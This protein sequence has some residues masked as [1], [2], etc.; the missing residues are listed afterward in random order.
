M[1][2]KSPRKRKK[3]PSYYADNTPPSFDAGVCDEPLLLF[4]GHHAHIDPKT[5]L[6]L[7]GPYSLADQEKPPLKTIKVGIVGPPGMVSDARNWLTTIQN[8]LLNDGKEPYLYP[9]F[10]GI[11]SE[12]AFQCD[13]V[14]G[15]TWQEAISPERLS[16]VLDTPDYYERLR[17]VV[18]L[19]VGR[20][21]NLSERTPKPDVVLCGIS[22]PI[23]DG[24]TVQRTRAGTVK[25]RKLSREEKTL[26]E[27]RARGV[28]FLFP[29][30]EFSL[31]IEDEDVLAHHDL[32][33]ALKAESMPFGLPTQLV[34]SRT[35]SLA[36]A[37]K[38]GERHLQDPA[39]RA[40]NFVTALYYKAG[41]H[42]WRLRDVQPG[43]CYVGISFYRERLAESSRMRTSLAQ[44]FTH[45]GDGLVLR[46]SPFEWDESQGKSP[47]LS[48]E[49]AFGLLRDA[50]ALYRRHLQCNP[51]RVVVHKSSRYWPQEIESFREALKGIPYW[52]LVAF[53]KRGIQF[54]RQG[55]YP[56]LR[57]TW[58][59][60]AADN[61][62]LYTQ[63]YVPYL[64]TY[65]AIRVPQPLEI[66]EHYGTAPP[67][68][69]LQE[70]LALTKMNW[71]S[72][73]FS[74]RQPITLE[75]AHRV[76][77]ILGELPSHISPR[78][79]YKFYM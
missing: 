58:V 14:F 44:V 48:R 56:P 10:P 50:L 65:P 31:G 29:E 23:V 24:C 32:R 75:F 34:L 61:F 79:E 64:R 35:L 13:V 33:R 68:K 43:T 47:H 57:G 69:V 49:G 76:G 77:D 22:D 17:S 6:G 26:K 52:D 9:H 1:K 54:L 5:G 46:G 74:C 42:P 20:I 21:H 78:D 18:M 53:G 25:R 73:D 19:Y 60:F 4:G 51:Q 62:L 37:S 28:R 12:T 16:E 3:Q 39:T 36:A 41:G 27:K 66:L 45:T 72:S 55:D 30:M 2:H 7:Y 63:G 15:E 38:P 8:R 11:R 67:D 70:V 71:N 59:K 40:W